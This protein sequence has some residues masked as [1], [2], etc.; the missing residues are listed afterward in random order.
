MENVDVITIGAG[1]GAYPGA[2]RLAAAGKTV[3]MVD[4]KGVMSG[5]CLSEG[6][7][8]SKAIREM[9]QLNRRRRRF[10]NYGIEGDA[11]V[12]FQKILQHKEDVQN[13]RYEM[14]SRELAEASNLTLMKGTAE[15]LDSHSVLVHS[16][17]GETRYSAGSVV[18][19]S[20]SE[21]ATPRIEGIENCISS[22][23]IFGL[24][25]ALTELPSSMAIIGGGYIGLETASMFAA[26]GTQ[27]TLL[28]YLPTV[29][30][31]MDAD[32]VSKLVSVL[33]PSIRLLTSSAVK[34]IE[35]T[36][37]GRRIHYVMNGQEQ[38]VEAECALSATGRRPVLPK[39]TEAAGIAFTPKGITVDM[40]MRT[41]V[42]GV[43]ATGDVNGLK[44]L[45][46]AAV[47]MSLVAANNILSGGRGADYVDL[48]SIPTTVFTLPAGAV[49]GLTRAEARQR[50][51]QTLE[52]YYELERDSRA[53]IFGETDGEIRLFFERET[54][55]LVGG[56]VIGIDAGNLIGEIGMALA[57]GANVHDVASFSDQHPM[58]SEGISA[59]ARQLV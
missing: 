35:R 50:G 19:A 47:R 2:F 45:F 41:N 13:A 39:G 28:E 40:A 1:G 48:P 14:H 38:T 18:I 24:H 32:F 23:D 22:G 42:S 17:E 56:W 58:A 57:L 43:Y 26:L 10:T 29:L 7:V 9:A 16:E 53:Q 6:C 34:R 11:S 20:G 33:D 5:N 59:A 55:K 21:T 25:P 51:I 27:V 52:G 44:P 49:V 3:V 54:M 12:N 31:N 30:S 36:G 15:F 46:H 8:P 4:T 37:N